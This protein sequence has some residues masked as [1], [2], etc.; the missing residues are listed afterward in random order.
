[1]HQVENEHEAISDWGV[2]EVVKRWEEANKVETDRKISI[3]PRTDSNGYPVLKAEAG[4]A[5]LQS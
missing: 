5:Y 1:M 4:F 2:E 3:L